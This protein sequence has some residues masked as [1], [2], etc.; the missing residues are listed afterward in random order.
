MVRRTEP[1][2]PIGEGV[3]GCVECLQARWPIIRAA[4]V[5]VVDSAKVEDLDGASRWREGYRF[6]ER[7][8]VVIAFGYTANKPTLGV[9]V[10]KQP[11]AMAARNQNRV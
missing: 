6:I 2:G 8:V 7:D 5:V 9:H 4:C 10:L 3:G 11:P 1:E